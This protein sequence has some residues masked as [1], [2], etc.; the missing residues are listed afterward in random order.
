MSSDR[1]LS[2]RNRVVFVSRSLSQ[3][4]DI[5]LGTMDSVPEMSVNVPAQDPD[6]LQSRLEAMERML[7]D[8]FIR[9]PAPVQ[10]PL[11][12]PFAPLQPVSRDLHDIV[13]RNRRYEFVL[14][15]STYRLRDQTAALRPDQMTSLSSIAALIRPRLEGSFFSGSPS[16]GILPFLSQVVRVADQT[17]ISEATLLWILEDFLRSPVKEAFRIQAHDTWPRA[18]HW[19][20]TSYAPETAL[21]SAVRKLQTTSQGTGENVREFGLRLQS[22]ASL[23]GPL[24]S[25]SELKAL[26]SQ[27]LNDPVCSHFAANQPATELLDIVPLS[28]LITRAEL[29]ERGTKPVT[30][31]NIPSHIRRNIPTRLALTVPNRTPEE[32]EMDEE[33][34]ILA[35][36]PA[37]SRDSNQ[38]SLTCFVCYHAGHPWL[39]CPYIRHLSSDEKEGCAYR[40]RLYYE[41]RKAQ[42]KGVPWDKPGWETGQGQVRPNSSWKVDSPTPPR[43][44]V[45]SSENAPTSP[46]K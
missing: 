31:G 33:L 22:E 3:A 44:E 46:R 1:V 15:V 21:E 32:N 42:W 6:D 27:G 34:S 39:E 17:H 13:V 38:R 16:L 41:K 30:S 8:L 29:L 36:D 37:F 40:R 7:Q 12:D 43:E 28:V 24:I 5:P 18:V 14:S 10:P 20:L 45:P 35:I 25:V 11:Q 2:L 23:F 19:L 9:I 4:C 26:F